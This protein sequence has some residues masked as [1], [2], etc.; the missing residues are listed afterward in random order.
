MSGVFSAVFAGASLALTTSGFALVGLEGTTSALAGPAFLLHH[1]QQ[2]PEAIPFRL[3]QPTSGGLAVEGFQDGLKLKSQH[4]HSSLINQP[5]RRWSPIINA[6][7]K[8][9]Q[10]R[11]IK[12]S[13]RDHSIKRTRSFT[14]TTSV[15]HRVQTISQ[16]NSTCLPTYLIFISVYKRGVPRGS[17]LYFRRKGK[18]TCVG[19]YAL[20]W[21]YRPP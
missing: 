9:T 21:A 10:K 11:I 4:S 7:V 1:Q 20:P 13:G 8:P 3:A 19:H 16:R 2:Q 6:A 17:K 14:I 12:L 18:N 5:H 15:C